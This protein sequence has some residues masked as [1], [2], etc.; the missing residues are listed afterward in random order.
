M[1]QDEKTGSK[2]YDSQQIVNF[3]RVL[4]QIR[5]SPLDRSIGID[6][7]CFSARGIVACLRNRLV[8]VG[9]DH[10]LDCRTCQENLQLSALSRQE[11]PTD[12]VA[13]ALAKVK[14]GGELSSGQASLEHGS[15]ECTD[16]VRVTFRNLKISDRVK[17]GVTGH[18]AVVDNIYLKGDLKTGT[19]I[20]SFSVQ[21]PLEFVSVE[22]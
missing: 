15:M 8:D 11:S 22:P 14:T 3:V 2:E 1:P 13:R 7:E 19:V 6:E 20:T 12:F 9:L 5:Q 18:P 10:L 21:A 4:S 17:K 16:C